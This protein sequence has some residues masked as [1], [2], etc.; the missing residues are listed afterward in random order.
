MQLIGS[1]IIV[2]KYT[3]NFINIDLESLFDNRLPFF[4]ICK[5]VKTTFSASTSPMEEHF[6]TL[7]YH[8]LHHYYSIMY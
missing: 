3:N 2:Q 8:N 5:T 6:T 1:S 7:K 4:I